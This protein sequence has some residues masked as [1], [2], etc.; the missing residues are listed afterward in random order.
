MSTGAVRRFG[1]RFGWTRS[2]LPMPRRV[3]RRHW[4]AGLQELTD[5]GLRYHVQVVPYLD[6]PA[7]VNFI[8]E[9]DEYSKLREFP[10]TAFQMCSTNPET[11]KLLDGMVQDLMNANRGGKY[12]HLST[13]EAWF[14]GK[15]NNDQ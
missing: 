6:G 11:Y 7:H 15:A 14:I 8:L 4:P 10:E 5:Y 3:R 2:Q 12:F 9:R 1:W 13:D